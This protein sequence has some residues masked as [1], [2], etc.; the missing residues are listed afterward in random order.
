MPS[1]T[2]RQL[3]EMHLRDPE[4]VPA[5]WLLAAAGLADIRAAA[6]W[7]GVT[8]RTIERYRANNKLPGPVFQALRLRAG[9]LS[10][11][12]GGH[13]IGWQIHGDTLTS[14]Y[15]HRITKGELINHGAMMARLWAVERELTHLKA[16]AEVLAELPAGQ[17]VVRFPDKR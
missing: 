12:L 13:F 17:N 4:E 14:D 1:Y 8:R 7:L 15:G 2:T 9:D 11:V 6:H 16:K 3:F 5:H 10:E